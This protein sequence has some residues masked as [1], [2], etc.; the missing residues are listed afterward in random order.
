MSEQNYIPWYQNKTILLT[1]IGAVSAILLTIIILIITTIINI[2]R[3][4]TE[5]V[6]TEY[7]TIIG[8]HDVDE[9]TPEPVHEVVHPAYT[10]PFQVPNVPLK[11]I[12]GVTYYL[13]YPFMPAFGEFVNA[14]NTLH[15]WEMI[16]GIKYEYE[17]DD[18]L[19]DA[20]MYS[21]LELLIEAGFLFSIGGDGMVFG[22]H[23][24]GTCFYLTP[25][26]YS[27][28]KRFS[29]FVYHGPHTL[30]YQALYNGV[31]DLSD[32]N[33]PFY[34]GTVRVPDFG[35]IFGMPVR[36]STW[37]YNENDPK[38]FPYEYTNVV[39]LTETFKNIIIDTY[40][41]LLGFA[42][43]EFI[44]Q[45]KLTFY[46]T[47]NE[48]AVLELFFGSTISIDLQKNKG[49]VLA[50]MVVTIAGEEYMT[51]L[52]S[53]DLRGKDLED[54]NV[55]SAFYNLQFLDIGRNN[56]SDLSPLTEL[57]KLEMLYLD[58]NNINDVSHLSNLTNL[59]SLWIDSN[60][61][62]DV[63]ALAE[64]TKLTSL[65]IDSNNISDISSLA[66]LSELTWFTARSNNISDISVIANF[67]KL[68]HL[69]LGRDFLAQGI[70]NNISDISA[71]KNLTGLSW[72]SLDH[73]NISD[74]SA[75]NGLRGLEFLVLRGNP[76]TQRHIYD[77]AEAL[78]LTDIEF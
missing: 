39:N 49:N 12:P 53:L 37:L 28:Y 6:P 54:I 20:L 65:K 13:D 21:Y 75:L 26:R 47:N 59:T 3:K 5:H 78:P 77:L 7:E 70:G 76:L 43:F 72:L 17:M 24:G 69:E 36:G 22:A 27:G 38:D 67:T 71:L 73:N 51:T 14:D 44:G 25:E 74:V 40:I 57:T 45:E 29:V 58:N 48:G 19:D 16:G 8:E 10:P 62:I 23:E 18:P 31:E 55:L 4:S 68:R 63:S 9:I 15:P 32:Y 30:W 1:L 56:I 64:L 11:Q 2:N 60:D 35:K 66:N 42:G 52:T 33:L 61:I 41:E 46:A 34:G 50:P